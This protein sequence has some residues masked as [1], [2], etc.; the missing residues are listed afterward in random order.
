MVSSKG[1]SPLILE[2]YYRN[3]CSFPSFST[4]PLFHFHSVPNVVE[5]YAA[6]QDDHYYYIVMEYCSRG[7]LLEN[8]LQDKR[9][10]SERRAGIDIMQPLLTTLAR[11]HALNIIH[12]DIK[13]ENIFLD[14][15]GRVYLGDFGLTMSMRQESAISPVGTVEYMAP[16][17]VALPAVDLVTSGQIRA[18][19]IPPT[20][21][22]VD[23]WALGVTLY[24]LVTGRL[25]FEGRDKAEIKAAISEYRLAA[26]P[27]FI[28]PQCQAMVRA[29]LSK[30][31]AKRPSAE[32]LLTHPYMQMYCARGS[33]THGGAVGRTSGGV[34]AVEVR[35][36]PMP[37][38]REGGSGLLPSNYRSTT[39]GAPLL[40]LPAP[41]SASS[42]EVS[43]H[44]LMAG[45]GGSSS[46]VTAIKTRSGSWAAVLRRLSAGHKGVQH[47]G[48]SNSSGVT[49]MDSSQSS[50]SS[51]SCGGRDC[52][53]GSPRG[54][55]T[56]GKKGGMLPMRRLF[57]GR[58]SAPHQLS[59][60]AQGN[61]NP[62][63]VIVSPFMSMMCPVDPGVHG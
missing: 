16:E 9:A 3:R 51:A 21:E 4:L 28:S 61:K 50:A 59:G 49:D 47:R 55:F 62:K 30:D 31:P 14:G 19:T 46:D 15:S 34:I 2:S 42:R 38:P 53:D 5:F 39:P 58:R 26:F 7:D 22:K 41:M 24:E 13:L 35:A 44:S 63:P 25:P 12:R 40:G 33:T 48:Q 17:V 32:E 27:A 18:S 45:C 8:L 37:T 54:Q 6:F 20:N 10:M 52:V 60:N 57:V 36:G 23:I 43:A 56:P 11:L 29:M 1:Y